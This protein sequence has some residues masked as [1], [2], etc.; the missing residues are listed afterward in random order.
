MKMTLKNISSYAAGLVL[1]SM[2]MTAC[3]DLDT[4]PENYWVTTSQK[5]EAIAVNSDLAQAGVVGISSSYNQYMQVYEAHCDFG[6]PAVLF[7]LESAGIDFVG[8]N[9]GYNW[10]SGSNGYNIGNTSNYLTN[11]AWYYGYKIISSANTVIAS[12]P[13][14]TDDAMLKLYAAQGYGN[15]AYIYFTLAQM[16]QYTYKGHESM[17]CVPIITDKN[18]DTAASEG[19]PR[20]TVQEVY[21]QILSDL[22]TAIE[23]LSSSGLS[24]DRIADSGSK[25]FFSLGTAYGL[26][27]RVNL[28]MNNWSAAASDAQNAIDNSGCTPYSIAEASKPAFNNADDHNLMWCIY[29]VPSDRV[30]TSGI[31]NWASHMGSLNYGYASVGAYRKINKALYNTISD[32][33]CRKGWWL[34]EDGVSANLTAPQQEFITGTYGNTDKN[35]PAPAY[36]QVKYAPYEGQ[37]NTSTN[38]TSPALMRV[39]E[40]YLIKAEATAKAGGD[41]ATILENF[42]KTYRDPSYSVSASG[43]SFDDEVWRQR[44]IELWGEGLAYFDLLRLNK[45]LDRRGGGWDVSWVYNVEAPLKPQLI[46]NSE[47]QNNPLLGDNNEAWS[48]PNSVA[49]Y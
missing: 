11:L 15:R 47:T 40:M 22:D 37:L 24:V 16:Y 39:E 31:V 27:A 4:L 41:G 2:A 1:V 45:G 21:D 30:V 9:T 3:A 12:I 36:I 32:T 14:D 8:L 29:I 49:D 28:V 25:R 7:N 35:E 38:S 44:R 13:A 33:D 43:L 17:P 23:L 20:A 42:V 18:S 26:R 34:N 6:W 10:F 46:P 5:E 19:A 48:K